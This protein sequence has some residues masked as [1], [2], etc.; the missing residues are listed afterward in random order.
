MTD[1]DTKE[2]TKAMQQDADFFLGLLETPRQELYIALAGPSPKTPKRKRPMTDEKTL[3]NPYRSTRPEPLTPTVEIDRHR[4]AHLERCEAVLD[5]LEEDASRIDPVRDYDDD[6][7]CWWLLNFDRRPPWWCLRLDRPYA[8][9]RGRSLR[10][11]V[12]DAKGWTPV[13]SPTRRT[14][15]SLGAL[16]LG[17]LLSTVLGVLIGQAA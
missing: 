8:K 6:S 1:E 15:V 11:A 7:S 14:R 16:T 10:E 2:H 12:E 3:M 4:L 13:P 5:V 17:I 9:G